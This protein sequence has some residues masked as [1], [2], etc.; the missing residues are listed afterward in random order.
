MQLKVLGTSSPYSKQDMNG[1]GFLITNNNTKIILDCGS[2]ITKLLDFPNDLHRLHII[3]SHLH[4]DH[5]IDLF[6]IGYASYV[7]KKLGLIV[8]PINVYIPKCYNIDYQLIHDFRE[9]NFIIND[10]DDNTILNI[11]N[12]K[13]TFLEMYHDIKTYGCK[14]QSDDKTLVYT[15][16]TGYSIKD[17][18]V[19]FAKH[20]DLLIS[21]AS[22]IREHNIFNEYHLHAYE[23]AWIAEKAGVKKLLLTHVWPETP[24]SSYLEEAKEIFDEVDVAQEEKVYSL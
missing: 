12:L 23:S 19:S 22:L 16:D 24:K 2:G 15:A 5:Y 18:L 1:P 20:A 11:D 10:Y 13:I 6:S 7:Y 14:I 17:R 9:H 4:K 3:I 8:D 21:E